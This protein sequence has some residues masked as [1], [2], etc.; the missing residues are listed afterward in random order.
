MTE[1]EHGSVTQGLQALFQIWRDAG[2]KV[3]L[4]IYDVPTFSMTVDLW[5]PRLFDWM[6]ERG[7]LE[8]GRATP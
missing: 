5:G 3:E 1:A 7:I 4:H 8:R 2:Q 6:I